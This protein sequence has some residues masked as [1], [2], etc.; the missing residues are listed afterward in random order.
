MFPH[1]KHQLDKLDFISRIEAKSLIR[2][3]KCESL[4]INLMAIGYD[5]RDCP[6]SILGFH[7]FLKNLYENRDIS[8]LVYYSENQKQAIKFD[9]IHGLKHQRKKTGFSSENCL[10]IEK[11]TFYDL[12]SACFTE[13]PVPSNKATL[14]F[15][16]LETVSYTHLTLPTILR[17]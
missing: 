10:K 9:K 1:L 17:V 6:A 12:V 11:N 7:M 14:A 15:L 2:S 3:A 8:E 13:G 5:K 4:L 16:N